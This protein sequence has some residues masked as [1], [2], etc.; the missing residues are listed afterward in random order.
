[1]GSEIYIFKKTIDK[2]YFQ[3]KCF[4]W[5]DAGAF[6]N[7]DLKLLQDKSHHST[8]CLDDVRFIFLLAFFKI[9]KEMI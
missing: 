1:M 4:Y 6:T 8:K 2:D 3:S 7:T 5:I 9:S